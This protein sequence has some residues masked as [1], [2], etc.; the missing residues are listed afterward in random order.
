MAAEQTRYCYLGTPLGQ[1]MASA[2][3]GAVTGF[4]FVGQNYFPQKAEDWIEDADYPVF[5]SLRNWFDRYFAGE[6]PL[7]DFPLAPQGT[8]FQKA[9]WDILLAIPHGK[10]S[11]YGAIAKQL[12]TRPG[13]PATSARAVGG[14]VGHNPISVLIPCHR[15]VG[16][17]GKLTGYAGGLEKKQALLRLEGATL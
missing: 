12:N 2:E 3:N 17:T 7:P 8:A 1:G 14:A 4:W 13:S 9:V 16:S 6:K 5:S 11:T 10:L 15:V